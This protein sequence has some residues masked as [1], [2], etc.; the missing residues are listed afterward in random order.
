MYCDPASA[1]SEPVDVSD[2]HV[3]VPERTT[4]DGDDLEVIAAVRLR[5]ALVVD[6]GDD[7]TV[8]VE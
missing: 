7:V 4:H 2:A 8:R 1:N 5:D 6:V 3:I